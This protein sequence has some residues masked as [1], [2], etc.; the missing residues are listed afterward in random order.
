MII[1]QPQAKPIDGVDWVRQ[2]CR[3]LAIPPLSS[4]G[5]SLEDVSLICAKA[6]VASSMKANPLW[7]TIPELHLILSAA[8]QG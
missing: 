4:Y 6:A 1:D 3:Q 7:L 8:L 5:I 2:L